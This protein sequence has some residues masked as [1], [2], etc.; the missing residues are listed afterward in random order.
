MDP[1]LL[2]VIDDDA[3]FRESLVRLIKSEGYQVIQ[4]A[5]ADSFLAD[6][7][8]EQVACTIIDLR[9]PGLSG[10]ELQRRIKQT[11]PHVGVVFLTGQAGIQESVHAMKD[12][13]VDF[14]VKPVPEAELFSAIRQ[15]VARSLVAKRELEHLTALQAKYRLLTRREREVFR[16]VAA[17]LLNKQIAFE[18]GTAERTIKAHRSQVMEKL[19]AESIAHLVRIADLLGV[20]T[21]KTEHREEIS[22][23]RF[24]PF[25]QTTL[26]K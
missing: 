25:R 15:A 17:G 13:A 8:H 14:L 7:V 21:V 26:T 1:K 20:E 16:F 18:L 9:M 5:S 4:F 12:G 24:A 19:G 11:L 10:I 6:P 2:A 23:R 22:G 3:A